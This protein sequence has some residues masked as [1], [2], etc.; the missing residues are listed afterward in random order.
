MEDSKKMT[1]QQV[2]QELYE[3]LPIFVESFLRER[4]YV[5]ELGHSINVSQLVEQGVRGLQLEPRLLYLNAIVDF[6]Q[7]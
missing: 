7:G 1:P 5:G 6:E 3:A 4:G 2:A